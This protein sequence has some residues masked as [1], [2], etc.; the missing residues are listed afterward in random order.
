MDKRL[1]RRPTPLDQA[2][3]NY[4]GFEI[5]GF[6]LMTIRNFSIAFGSTLSSRVEDQTYL[7]AFCFF[8]YILNTIIYFFFTSFFQ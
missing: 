6:K 2:E 5:S 1:S 3:T 4:R 7:Y 8:I